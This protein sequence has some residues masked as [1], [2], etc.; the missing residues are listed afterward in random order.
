MDTVF[1]PPCAAGVT[2]DDFLLE[3]GSLSADLA[4]VLPL[5]GVGAWIKLYV[6]SITKQG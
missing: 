5:V 1:V 6:P 4:G 3:F 2:S